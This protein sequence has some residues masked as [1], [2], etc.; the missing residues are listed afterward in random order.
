MWRRVEGKIPKASKQSSK[1]YLKGISYE[2][3]S[4]DILLVWSWKNVQERH[5]KNKS[6]LMFKVL[7]NRTV[8]KL[9]ASFTRMSDCQNDYQLRN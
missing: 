4:S 7:N 5:K 6:L 8:P 3:R 2:T 1:S 9:R